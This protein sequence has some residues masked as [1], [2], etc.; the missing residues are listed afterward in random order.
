M[1]LFIA[2]DLPGELK[3][4]LWHMAT[5]LR[6]QAEQ[7]RLVP[8]QNFHLTLLFIGETKRINEA[9]DILHLPSSFHAPF[10]LALEGIGSFKQPRGRTWWVGIQE[11]TALLRLQNELDSL[12]RSAGFDIEKR[13]YHPH[14]TIARGVSASMPMVLTAPQRTIEVSSISL[15]KSSFE[16][17]NVSYTIID[18]F[19]LSE[20]TDWI[21]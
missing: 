5:S 21:Q 2:I 7:A 16:A 18:S 15:F 19:D 6:H 8:L 13:A 20:R 3:E 12:Y 17:K 11:N 9:C 10:E 1:R 14:I 4:E